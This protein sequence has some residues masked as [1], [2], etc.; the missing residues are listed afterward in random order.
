MHF[1]LFETDW[2]TSIEEFRQAAIQNLSVFLMNITRDGASSNNKLVTSYLRN[3]TD[4]ICSDK[5]C[6]LHNH[7]AIENSCVLSIGMPLLSDMFRATCLMKMGG[8]LS[9]RTMCL[10]HRSRL[11]VTVRS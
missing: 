10:I 9:G 11:Y 2:V 5:V 7:K 8:C 3:H 1:G 6:S 4:L